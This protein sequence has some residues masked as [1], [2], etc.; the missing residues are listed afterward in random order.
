MRIKGLLGITGAQVNRV[1]K[2]GHAQWI[3][4]KNSTLIAT[5]KFSNQHAKST[6]IKRN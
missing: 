5:K 2:N 4:G 6:L 3:N 1:I